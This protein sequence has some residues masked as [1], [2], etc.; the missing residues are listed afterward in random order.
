MAAQ[1]RVVIPEENADDLRR[2]NIAVN[3]VKGHWEVDPSQRSL[4]TRLRANARVMIFLVVLLSFAAFNSLWVPLKLEQESLMHPRASLAIQAG[5]LLTK[6]QSEQSADLCAPCD[7]WSEIMSS[8]DPMD[9]CP[10]TPESYIDL[11]T[12]NYHSARGCCHKAEQF[13]LAIQKHSK[14]LGRMKVG[15]VHGQ[16]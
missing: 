5:E 11:Y 4:F 6:E 13:E 10:A 1:I 2:D 14:E 7:T 8:P 12:E 16:E 15:T 9:I 3:I